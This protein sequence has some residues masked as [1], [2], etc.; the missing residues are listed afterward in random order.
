MCRSATSH[1]VKL[2]YSI[3]QGSVL[4]S[5]LFTL[6]TTDLEFHAAYFSV[7]I[8]TYADDAKSHIHCKSD[9]ISSAAT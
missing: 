2:Q 3:P 6:Y 8:P 5:M 1:K 7:L 9:G 4:G